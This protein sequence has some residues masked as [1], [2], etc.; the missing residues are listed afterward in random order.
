MNAAIK[1]DSMLAL[2]TRIDRSR[3]V[4]QRGVR[5][6]ERI[7]EATSAVLVEVGRDRLSTADVAEH[8]GVSI[9]SIYRYFPDRAALIEAV[10]EQDEV[11]VAQ[12]AVLDA[13]AAAADDPND[14]LS[15]AALTKSTA[16]L[17][18][19]LANRTARRTWNRSSRIAPVDLPERR[20]GGDT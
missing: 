3:P 6:C 1:G 16:A 17:V 20:V 13:A 5:T 12:L 11:Y 9:G 10:L 7:L 2:V 8:A 15:S 14:R 19:A 4:Q 18:G